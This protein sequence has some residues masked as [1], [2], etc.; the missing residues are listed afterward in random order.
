[1]RIMPLDPAF[2]TVL[3]TLAEAGALPLVRDGDPVATREH[4]RALAVAR[5]GPDFVPEQV[6][7]VADDVL[8]GPGGG[9]PVRTYTPADDRGALVLYLHGGGW[10]TG[11]LETHDPVCRHVA[12]ATGAVLVAVDYR[13]SPEHPHPAPLEDAWAALLAVAG[14]HP[15]RPLG[16]AGDSAGAN[17]AA[18]LALRARD[19][20]GP[21][22]AGQLL[23]YPPLDPDPATPSF[24]E[25]A[26]GYFLTA[27]DMRWFWAQYLAGPEPA[28]PEIAPLGTATP[29][30]PSGVAPAVVATAEFD[31]LRDE[32]R[33]WAGALAAAGVP[34]S[35]VEG[36]GLVHGF[37][38]FLGAVPAAE[39]VV[40]EALD[41][42]AALLGTSA[43]SHARDTGDTVR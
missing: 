13:R 17:L 31:P 42:F 30:D 2:R 3:D 28:G 8:D 19:R 25:N 39:R 36:P 27:A 20:G 38:A 4:Y 29:A 16:V 22:L 21:V 12:N 15:D 34:V 26:E 33:D 23:F 5:R 35:T 32:G 24:Q 10:V 11:D 18:G 9:I 41:R 43:A 7:A 6:A 1:M 40:A 14:R 37:V